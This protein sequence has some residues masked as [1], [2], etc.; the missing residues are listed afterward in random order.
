MLAFVDEANVTRAASKNFNKSFDW[1]K[2][3]DFLIN[4]RDSTRDLAEMLVYLGIPPDQQRREARLRYA[5]FLK[6][7][8]FL[9]HIKEGQFKS[10][11]PSRYPQDPS[12]PYSSLDYKANV[13]VLMAIDA[14]EYSRHVK[15]DI[16]TLA[17]GDSDFA[18]LAL[19]LRRQ[20]IK[21]EVAAVSQSLSSELRTSVNTVIDLAELFD[22]FETYEPRRPMNDTQDRDE[23]HSSYPDDDSP[24]DI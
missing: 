21:V 12:R 3:K 19:T 4:R 14:M 24:D 7:L 17:T 22:T 5:H 9:V 20:G 10:Y 15:P 13:N 11:G 6:S 8:G 2:F 16:V 18:H 23:I 1:L